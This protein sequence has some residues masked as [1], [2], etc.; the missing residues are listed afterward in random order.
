MRKSST[1]RSLWESGDLGALLLHRA[2]TP[3]PPGAHLPAAPLVNCIA[4]IVQV[5][6]LGAVGEALCWCRACLGSDSRAGLEWS[7]WF[8]QPLLPSCPLPIRL[9]LLCPGV[10]CSMVLQSTS[11]SVKLTW[12][13]SGTPCWPQAEMK[14]R[15]KRGGACSKL[16]FKCV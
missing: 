2:R 5:H 7:C 16:R 4:S 15:T 8:S 11:K 10:H 13:V 14:K 3:L 12:A 1:P 6:L 9:S